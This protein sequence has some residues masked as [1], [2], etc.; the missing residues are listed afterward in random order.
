MTYRY[1]IVFA[2]EYIQGDLSKIK[3]IPENAAAR[4]LATE[5]I[6]TLNILIQYYEKGI[7]RCP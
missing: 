2:I 5:V 6:E 3:D 1:A 4:A 7:L